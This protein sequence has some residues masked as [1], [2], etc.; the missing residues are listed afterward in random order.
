[1]FLSWDILKAMLQ[2][3]Y[4]AWQL[5]RNVSDETLPSD[6]ALN[7]SIF[8]P[9]SA[10]TSADK[11]AVAAWYFNHTGISTETIQVSY[12]T[13]E[14]EKKIANIKISRYIKQAEKLLADTSR[15][16][17]NKEPP[18]FYQNSH[19]S[20]CQFHESCYQ[21]LRERDCLSLLSGMPPKVL[22]NYH[23]RGLFSIT[24]LSHT[25]R[26]K[27]RRSRVPES[28][29][30]LWELKALA[31][32]EQK[33]FVM[34]TPEIEQSANAIYLDFE[35]I[36]EQNWVYLIG[37][38]IKK[39]NEPDQ[40]I[41][42]WANN[43]EEEKEV[44]GNLFSILTLYSDFPVY[45]YGSYESKA[46]K[47][48]SKKWKESFKEKLP[49]IEARL[50]NLLSYL[51]THV[52]PP[53]YGNGLKELGNFLGFEWKDKEASGLLSLEWRKQWE[54]TGN[55]LWKEKLVQYN[56]D[57]CYALDRVT[58]WFRKLATDAKQEGV[59]QVAEMKR[60]SL[61][62]FRKNL[63]DED[64]GYINQAA[65]FDYQHS[66]IYWRNHKILSPSSKHFYNIP[67]KH[68]GKGNA[69]WKPKKVNEV[70]IAPPLKQC[71]RCGHTKL[72]QSKKRSITRQTDLRF[73]S[74]GIKQHVIEYQSARA[75][76]A[77]C[78]LNLSNRNLRMMRFGDNLFAWVINLYV[79][80]HISH[81]MIS[82]LL[83]EQ[84]NIP[85]PRQYLLDRKHKW[86]KSNWMQEVEYL[87]EIIRHSPVMHID[88][89]SIR[90]A[91]DKGYVWVF[92]SSHTV[93]YYFSLSREA[94]FLHEWLK[95]Y[96]G[97]IVSD[98]F[99]G[100]ENLPVKRQKCLIHLI[101]DLNDDLF[102]NPFDEEYKGMV[103]AFGKL[104]R[105]I[106][107]TIDQYGLQKKQ[108]QKHVKDTEQFFQ[109]HIE[110]DYKSELSIKYSKRLRKHWEHL[111]TFLHH[112]DVPWNNNNAEAAIKAF[113][114]YRRG[115]NGQVAENTLQ[116]F[117]QML[118]IA[119]TCR[120]RNISFL[121]FLRRK[122]GLWENIYQEALPGFLPFA[123][124]RL[125]VH[126]LGFER[127]QE[128]TDWK[129]AGKRPSFIPSNPEKI[130]VTK[131]WVDWH[132]WLGFSFL[133]FPDAR[134]YMRRLG[135]K[136]RND[137]W[138]WLRSGKRPKSIPYSPEKVYRYTGWKDLGDWLGTGNTGQQRKPRMSYEQAKTYIKA[139]G[140]KTQKD[141]FQWRKTKERPNTFPPDPVKTYVHEFEGWGKFL[142]TDRIANQYKE[143]WDYQQAKAFLKVLN[144]RSVSHYRKLY[145]SSLIPKEIPKN[146]WA[147]YKKKNTWVSFP[148]FWSKQYY[149]KI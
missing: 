104:L 31:I 57:D 41:S 68:P 20:Q 53:I 40:I 3:P 33:T 93:F 142:G 101:R 44:F 16:V 89:T 75:K 147:Y 7:L 54:I 18:S 136:N 86:W 135:L 50:V 49:G 27:R 141:F 35:G 8:L 84:F 94:T 88:E 48:I 56:L 77:K 111:W 62:K 60:V 95:D 1:M 129:N 121:D 36:P 133:P 80:Y 19:C 100:Y 47:D 23:K 103:T 140:I 85:V 24:Q 91:K 117:L 21:K 12:G 78:S 46:L 51:R 63:Y 132:D 126:R 70:I 128:W 29:K 22:N 139:V 30:Y 138:A 90:L 105:K 38:V 17:G 99:P 148:D 81:E 131:G 5:Y 123:Q 42:Y 25:F 37:L 106:I 115:V 83:Q 58:K 9:I 45:H 43:R 52:Y 137:Y 87:K 109:Q 98:F 55:D 32:R 73:T 59:Q 10:I 116:N 4:K 92:A 76:C 102:K 11:I 6:S 125:F 28:G 14:Q 143:Y 107:E 82:R 13:I 71:K 118:S 130:Y 26:P 97:V 39:E 127:K 146:P 113:A 66:K 144:I 145:E 2:C 67:E 79:C 34:H 120:Y 74:S 72:Y 134:T 122:T 96:K 110:C 61:Y 119:Q 15:T 124:A 65:Y 64:F 108:L 112:D 149:T 114:Q 69:G